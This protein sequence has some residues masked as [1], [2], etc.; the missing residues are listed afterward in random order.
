MERVPAD[1]AAEGVAGDADV[2]RGAVEG[3]W[4]V[5][6]RRLG[7]VDP[8]GTALEPGDAA[9]RVDGDTRHRRGAHH[10]DVVEALRDRRSHVV[11]GAL[12]GDVQVCRGGGAHD[13]LHLDHVGGVGDCGRTLVD[14]EVPGQAGALVTG[15]AGQLTVPRPRSAS[16]RC[17]VVEMVMV[18]DSL[19]RCW[20]V[21]NTVRPRT[22][23]PL[24]PDLGSG[25]VAAG[26]RACVEPAQRP[27]TAALSAARGSALAAPWRRARAGGPGPGGRCRG[28]SPAAGS[29]ARRRG[30]GRTPRRCPPR[31]RRRC[32]E[33]SA[34]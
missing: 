15:L 17:R 1:P 23:A 13:L 6:G 4:A 34:A 12:R 25:G 18:G 8:Q 22:W 3:G 10:D 31:R 9:H 27:V 26:G 2:G 24:G 21:R 5:L 16:A 20:C 29:P 19:F 28:C 11:A 30:P 14:C 32:G 7:G 33:P